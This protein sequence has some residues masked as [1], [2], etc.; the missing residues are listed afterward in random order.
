MRLADIQI[1]LSGCGLPV[2]YRLFQEG[3]APALPYVVW[4]VGSERN[5]PADGVNY[6][7][8]KELTVELYT[9]HKDITSETKIERVLDQMG[10]WSKTEAYIDSEKCFQVVYYLE[11]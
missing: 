3:E 11:V 8:I 10:I 4:Y 1:Q 5:F 2:A 6:H 9:P 7:N